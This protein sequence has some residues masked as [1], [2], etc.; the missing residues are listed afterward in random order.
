M[1]EPGATYLCAIYETRVVLGRVSGHN[2]KR[3]EFLIGRLPGI[4][5]ELLDK[6]QTGSQAELQATFPE[7]LESQQVFDDADDTYRKN[8]KLQI[9]FERPDL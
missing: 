3:A 2:L 1:S 4:D 8:P 5:G 7:I 9:E 6:W